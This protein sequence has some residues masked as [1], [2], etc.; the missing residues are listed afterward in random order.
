VRKET[1]K[2]EQKTKRETRNSIMACI[3]QLASLA[4][5]QQAILENLGKKV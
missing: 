5:L 2:T 4:K 1:K 3:K